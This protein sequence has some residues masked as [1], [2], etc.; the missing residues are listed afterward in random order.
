MLIIN[1]YKALMI[2]IFFIAFTPFSLFVFDDFTRSTEIKW[3][4]QKKDMKEMPELKLNIYKLLILDNS[5]FNDILKLEK[6]QFVYNDLD[7]FIEVTSSNALINNFYENMI[8]NIDE[9]EFFSETWSEKK[10]NLSIFSKKQNVDFSKDY[11]KKIFV[12]TNLQLIEEI[13]NEFNKL[14]LTKI[15]YIDEYISQLNKNIERSKVNLKKD[16]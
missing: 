2:F 8:K 9:V 16:I 12:F 3:S 10:F 4:Y 13:R 7:Q 6:S 1:K 14:I 5:I 11:I 15:G